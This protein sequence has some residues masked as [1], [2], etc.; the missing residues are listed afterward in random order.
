MFPY[1]VARFTGKI[2]LHSVNQGYI[3]TLVLK[4]AYIK[5]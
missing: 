3:Y 2:T 4:E 5:L 1:P